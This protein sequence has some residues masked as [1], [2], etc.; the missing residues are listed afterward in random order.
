MTKRTC[1]RESDYKCDM[2]NDKGC[3]KDDSV[4][5]RTV[6]LNLSLTRRTA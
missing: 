3:D 6:W 4:T 1:G 5:K 2:E